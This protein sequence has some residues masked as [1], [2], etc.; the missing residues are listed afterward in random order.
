MLGGWSMGRN[1]LVKAYHEV[2]D[3]DDDGDNE[4]EEEWKGELQWNIHAF[5]IHSLRIYIPL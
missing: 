4:E 2:D 1:R 5:Q 3:D